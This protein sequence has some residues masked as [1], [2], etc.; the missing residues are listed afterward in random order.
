MINI[1]KQCYPYYVIQDTTQLNQFCV[2][3]KIPYGFYQQISNWYFKK[4]NAINKYNNI[5]KH[6][7]NCI[8]DKKLY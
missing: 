5:L 6:A 3:I 4:G 7:T 8:L 1:I 2:M